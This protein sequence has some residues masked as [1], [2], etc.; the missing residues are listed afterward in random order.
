[1]GA[2]EDSRR[3]EYEIDGKLVLETT[4][5]TLNPEEIVHQYKELQDV[6]RCFRP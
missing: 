3:W 6:E 2:D 1:M 4:N 5:K